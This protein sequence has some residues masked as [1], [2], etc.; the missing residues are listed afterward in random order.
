MK[1]YDGLIPPMGGDVRGLLV[2]R[3]AHAR[4]TLQ[5]VSRRSLIVAQP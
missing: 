3:V 2:V 5:P 1:V 4:V